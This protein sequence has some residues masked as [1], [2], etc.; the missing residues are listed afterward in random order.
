MASYEIWNCFIIIY[1]TKNFSKGQTIYLNINED[2]FK[3]VSSDSRFPANHLEDEPFADFQKA[4]RTKF[5]QNNRVNIDMICHRDRNNY[6]QG[7]AFLAASVLAAY[8]MAAEEERS[9][10]NYFS[11]LR[12]ILNF[13]GQGRPPGIS[14]SEVGKEVKLWN[15]WNLWLLEN[16]YHPSAIQGNSRPQKYIN[17]P[18]SQCVLRKADKDQLQKIFQEKKWHNVWDPETLLW[19]IKQEQ[20]RVSRHIREV[21]ESQLQRHE[22]LADA[23]YEVYEEHLVNFYEGDRSKDTNFSKKKIMA[24]LYREEDPLSKEVEYYIYPKQ[25]RGYYRKSITLDLDGTTQ[26]IYEDQPGWYSPLPQPIDEHILNEGISY[27]VINESE[28]EEV[29]LPARR[30]WILVADPESN[31]YASWK[32]PDLGTKFT[33]LCKRQLQKDVELLK[34]EQLIEYAGEPQP[35]SENS[36]WLEFE[37]CM[38]TSYLWDGIFIEDRELKDSLKPKV[39]LSINLSGGLRVPGEKA[40]LAEYPPQVTVFGFA[41]QATIKIFNMSDSSRNVD[42]KRIMTN[43]AYDLPKLEPG[44]YKIEAFYKDNDRY[45]QQQYFKILSW[46]DLEVYPV[47]HRESVLLNSNTSICGAVLDS[48]VAQ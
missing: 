11:R 6:P 41:K 18:I 43:Q 10:L 25:K 7:V 20:E 19:K 16:G 3:K 33:L 44:Y 28:L 36:D 47:H 12:E 39:K 34:E 29:I 17:Y 24:D 8:N 4:I 45:N 5:I 35:I 48:K 32:L 30:F 23:I 37:E 2:T 40:W 13:P 46:E 21:L 26:E 38:V 14:G 15:D 27:K 1:F 42:P 22:V 9:E 31:I